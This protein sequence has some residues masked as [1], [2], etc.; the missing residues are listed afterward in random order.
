MI[1]HDQKETPVDMRGIVLPPG[2]STFV[3]ITKHKTI[4]LKKPYKTECGSVP[5]HYFQYY[6][7]SACELEHLSDHLVKECKC[8]VQFM[9]GK[10]RI[11][12]LLDLV[13]CTWPA[14][15]KF[16]NLPSRCPLACESVRFE[17]VISHG[18]YPSNVV[19]DFKAK[20]L[21]LPGSVQENRRFIRDNFLRVEVYYRGMSYS[22]AEQVPTYDL[23]VFFGDIGGQLGLFLGASILTYVEFLDLFIMLIYTKYF[24]RFTRKDTP[25][26]AADV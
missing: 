20:T 24:E 25:R 5:L 2:L 18:R 11:C 26:M 23:M 13:N 14:W 3:E 4:N 7:Q 17:P 19:A 22:V 21:D 16:N 6:S 8:K 1:L 10:K 12:S 15:E 9:R